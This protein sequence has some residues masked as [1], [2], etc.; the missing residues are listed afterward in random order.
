MDRARQMEFD[1]AGWFSLER[2]S[3]ETLRATLERVLREAILAGALRSGVRLP[4]SRILAR[5]LG[6][7]RGVVSDAYDQLESQGFVI[8][9]PRSAPVVAPVVR[10]LTASPPP[11]PRAPAPRYD[12]VPTAPDVNLFPL[13]RWLATVQRVGRETGRAM[14]DYGDSQGERALRDALADHLGRTR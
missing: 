8:T 12:L 3:G 4:A 7:S 5:Q 10:A 9:R 14:L 13:A 6:V 2:A 11:Q 1:E